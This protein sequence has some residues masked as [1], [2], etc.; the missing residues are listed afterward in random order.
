LTYCIY[1]LLIS[2][3]SLIISDKVSGLVDLPVGFS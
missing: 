3:T 2:K 1:F